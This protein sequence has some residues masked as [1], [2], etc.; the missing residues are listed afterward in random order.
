MEN[1]ITLERLH[2]RRLDAISLQS[3]LQLKLD[4]LKSEEKWLLAAIGQNEQGFPE[5][6]VP[7]P[8][9]APTDDDED[10][11]VHELGHVEQPSA[12]SIAQLMTQD[13]S[14]EEEGEEEA[15]EE[16]P[17]KKSKRGDNSVRAASA[18]KATSARC[19]G[20]EPISVET[21]GKRKIGISHGCLHCTIPKILQ[22]AECG[23]WVSVS[24]MRQHQLTG[25]CAKYQEAQAASSKSPHD[26][27][28][29]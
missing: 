22:C 23:Y 13:D 29:A 27:S 7:A 26:R 10:R 20:H 18:H 2:K 24:S 4:E 21:Y 6:V 3:H 15:E 12:A 5:I 1:L 11:V 9:V 17:I 25:L 8:S 28:D 14:S 19:P 16:G